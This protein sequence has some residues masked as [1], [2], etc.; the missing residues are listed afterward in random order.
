MTK[1]AK[2]SLREKRKQRGKHKKKVKEEKRGPS[3]DEPMGS[4]PRRGSQKK[5]GEI[6][7]DE[8]QNFLLETEC[9][10]KLLNE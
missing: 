10:L 9:L 7:S 4:R 6:A 8:S 1:K 5:I 2:K 3:C